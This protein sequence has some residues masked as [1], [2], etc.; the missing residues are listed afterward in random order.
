MVNLPFSMEATY[1]ASAALILLITSP[2]VLQSDRSIVKVSGEGGS[3]ICTRLSSIP[4]ISPKVSIIVLGK[5]RV[6]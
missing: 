6:S 4:E 5:A 3:S 1:P 2:I